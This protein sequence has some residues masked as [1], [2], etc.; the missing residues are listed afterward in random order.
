M[1]DYCGAF[2]TSTSKKVKSILTCLSKLNYLSK[3][4][5]RLCSPPPNPHGPELWGAE[6]LHSHRT[7]RTRELQCALVAIP[8]HLR[9]KASFA[10]LWEHFFYAPINVKPAVVGG[11]GEEGGKEAGREIA[12]GLEYIIYCFK[13][14]YPGRKCEVK[15]N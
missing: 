13:I 14:P 11:G 9:Q 7:T 15:Y 3:M 6:S 8:L 12:R 4:F 2:S 5:P 1:T 10:P